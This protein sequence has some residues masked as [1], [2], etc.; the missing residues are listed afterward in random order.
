MHSGQGLWTL[1]NI[2]SDK[3]K[4]GSAPGKEDGKNIKKSLKL[5]RDKIKPLFSN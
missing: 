5:S 2:I 3:G 1:L 4:A